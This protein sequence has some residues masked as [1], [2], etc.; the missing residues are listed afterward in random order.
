MGDH[1]KITWN[2]AYGRYEIEFTDFQKEQALVKSL[3][4][5]TTGPPDWV[6][7]TKRIEILHRLQKDRPESGLTMSPDARRKYDIDKMVFDHKKDK[8]KQAREDDKFEFVLPPGKEYL[9]R[10]DLPPSTYKFEFVSTTPV[11]ELRCGG[12]GTPVW[13]YE[14]QDP[15]LCLWC[16][17][18]SDHDMLFEVE[19]D[20]TGVLAL[21][22]L[23]S[24][25]VG[26]EL[27]NSHLG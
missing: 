12:C 16:E 10:E 19:E 23:S 18:L 14:R 1:M 27:G 9:G 13:F 7:Y 4:F 5:K 2:Q 11:P 3:G 25:R 21:S 26:C 15:P 6:W 8:K 22:S 17:K 20:T 24:K